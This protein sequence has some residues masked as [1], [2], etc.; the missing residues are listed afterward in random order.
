MEP[1]GVGDPGS[2]DPGAGAT[3]L[4]E[5]CGRWKGVGHQEYLGASPQLLLGEDTEE[6]QS[7]DSERGIFILEHSEA[8]VSSHQNSPLSHLGLDDMFGLVD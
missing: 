3:H 8:G 5:G 7:G 6:L 1:P 2:Q 4:E